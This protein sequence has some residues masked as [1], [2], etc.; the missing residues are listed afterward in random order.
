M[1]PYRGIIRSRP[2][3]TK[4]D[5][6]RFI[7]LGDADPNVVEQHIQQIMKLN[8]AK[9]AKKKIKNLIV[10]RAQA[11]V[12]KR[13]SILQNPKDKVRNSILLQAANQVQRH[14]MR[15]LPQGPMSSTHDK[16]LN[17]SLMFEYELLN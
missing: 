13:E 12:V 8:N 3:K 10:E 11:P 14:S 5:F 2:K 16:Q 15:A 4:K 1:E 6:D 7:V 9:P 17:Q